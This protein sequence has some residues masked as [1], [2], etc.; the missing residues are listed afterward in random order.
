MSFYSF[1]IK[2]MVHKDSLIPISGDDPIAQ[3]IEAFNGKDNKFSQAI[4]KGIKKYENDAR[5]SLKVHP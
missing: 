3:I 4:T 1:G 5:T 2:N